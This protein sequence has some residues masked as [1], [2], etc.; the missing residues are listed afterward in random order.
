VSAQN[1]PFV[2]PAPTVYEKDLPLWRFLW[3]LTRSTLA[4]WPNRAFETLTAKNRIMGLEFLIANDPEAVRHV[5][6]SNP[7]NYRSPTSV[8][9]VARP[10]V[11]AGLFLADGDDWRRQRRLLAPAFTPASINL[12]L[13]HFQG[14]GLHVLHSIGSESK[15]NLSM[16][17]RKAAW[18][19]VLRALFSTPG[20][21][22]G[23]RL[24]RLVLS[25]LEGPGRPTLFDVF[26][27]SED[28]F[29]F[30][31]VRRERF[32]SLW[33][34]AI[35]GIISERQAQPSGTGHRDLLDLLLSLKDADTGAP[36]S[37]IEIRDQCAT[38]L[39]AGS[40]TTARL[41]FWAVYLLTQDIEEQAKSRAEI[42]AFPPRRVCSLNDLQ[43]W[44]RL[45]N[46]LLEALRLYPPAAFIVR[47]AIDADEVG[48]ERIAA[49]TQ[50]WFS[51]WVMHRHR[52]FWDQPTAFI[53]DRFADKVAPWMQTRS[54]IPFG[55]GPRTCI[56]SSFALSEA[57][58]VL[59]M[60]LERHK[61]SLPAGKPVLPI[62]RTMIEP[63]YDP[64]FRLEA[65]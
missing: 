59:A 3:T 25:Y 47:E 62:G 29:A 60:L 45:R 7:T 10:L 13:P 61:I 4:I 17:F 27:K 35:E 2:P 50:V 11:G 39:F 5:L 51:A 31:N 23:E 19:V 42:V 46:V 55:A 58:V 52:K 33:F 43:H 36:L 16:A 38:M 6:I 56:G 20:D 30:S 8:R 34:T 48:G 44:P 32:Q 49:K 57:Q 53:P 28:A 64:I 54:Y 63:S 15:V 9:R 22:A 18:E 14:A 24:N 41:M 26:A 1:L 12:L 21:R 40:E 37:N 65:I